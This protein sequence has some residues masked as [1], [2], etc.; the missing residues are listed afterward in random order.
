MHGDEVKLTP[1]ER[2]Q[3]TLERAEG[4]TVWTNYSGASV[5]VGRCWDDVAATF[6]GGVQDRLG[7]LLEDCAAQH[8]AASCGEREGWQSGRMRRS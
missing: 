1:I 7:D 6:I 2:E 8:S 5:G 3:G 4:G